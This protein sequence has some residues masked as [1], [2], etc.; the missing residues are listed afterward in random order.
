MGRLLLNTRTGGSQAT[1]VDARY[2][3]EMPILVSPAREVT[4]KELACLARF[5]GI[6]PAS[7]LPVFPEK[8]RHSINQLAEGFVCGL[9]ENVPSVTHTILKTAFNLQPFPWNDV[10]IARK[11][12]PLDAYDPSQWKKE[13]G[14]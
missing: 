9:Q 8:S 4:A 5:R 13:V 6:T 14:Y 3:H 2:G 11:R 10:D 12:E 7:P 1:L